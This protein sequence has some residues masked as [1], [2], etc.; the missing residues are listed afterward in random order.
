MS[1]LPPSSETST[2]DRRLDSWKEVAAYLR[3]SVRTVQSWE[4]HRGLPVHRMSGP[5]GRIWTTTAE[6][7][8][9]LA[10]DARR[11]QA[12][13]VPVIPSRPA[14]I[15]PRG[16]LALGLVGLGIFLIA[17]SL[18][19]VDQVASYRLE[20][21]VLVVSGVSGHELWRYAFDARPM[22]PWS[23]DPNH[24][25]PAP[26]DVDGDGIREFLFPLWLQTPNVHQG[27]LIC[28]T[29]SGK[30]K[31]DFSLGRSVTSGKGEQ[32]APPYVVWAYAPVRL[33]SGRTALAVSSHHN[34]EYPGQ[35][36]LLSPEGQLL[37]QYWHSGHLSHMIVTDLNSDG[38]DELCL[39]GIANGY[40]RIALVV[41]DP[42]R[43][44]GASA[45]KDPNYRLLGLGAPVEM[46][47][48]L[49]PRSSPGART[50]DYAIPA[51]LTLQGSE[52]ML[53]SLEVPGEHGGALST[54]FGLD[55]QFHRTVPA[56]GFE[57]Q[58]RRMAAQGLV[59]TTWEQELSSLQR[60]EILTAPNW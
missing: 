59:P 12:E 51:E 40:R 21:N 36:A 55:L 52:L 48:F 28:F 37:R 32:F 46:A 13:P 31:W 57:S 4:S 16:L 38:K 30:V 26:L 5:K 19:P 25:A 50:L 35:V 43:M 41:L 29:N 15:A 33:G 14:R 22:Q 1:P 49:L 3:V 34:Y 45:E 58:F 42:N 8:L 56:V 7:D 20:G 2:G 9:W 6:L 11:S 27:R 10:A 18:S 54:Y 23:N 60:I 44:R 39:S 47:R 24:A 53:S 17:W